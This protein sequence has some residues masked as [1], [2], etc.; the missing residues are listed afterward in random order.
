M[1]GF[2]FN[3]NFAWPGATC[4]M[5]KISL[6]NLMEEN[7]DK[8]W[9]FRSNVNVY[10]IG[11]QYRK[12]SESSWHDVSI[13]KSQNRI[14]KFSIPGFSVVGNHY[15][16]FKMQDSYNGYIY[17]MYILLRNLDANT[18]Y[19][20]RSYY[21]TSDG[22]SKVTYNGQTI[23]TKQQTQFTCTS[24]SFASS[25]SQDKIDECNQCLQEALQVVNEVSPSSVRQD[26]RNF[27]CEFNDRGVHEGGYQHI[28]IYANDV[29]VGVILHELSH[30]FMQKI[31]YDIYDSSNVQ[32]RRFIEKIIEF[33]EFTTHVPKAMWKWNGD[34]NYPCIC[35]KLAD[36]DGYFVVAAW[37]IT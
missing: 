8:T 25:L 6:D 36:I 1:E 18:E 19:I 32:N 3:N 5:Y 9:D 11:V 12:T 35:S 27:T 15:V 26:L 13:I 17:P 24:V 4:I 16:S 31:D 7:A 33:M 23:T 20:V 30:C 21:T 29:G 28:T 10:E 37:D 22:G 14:G 2:M 34:H